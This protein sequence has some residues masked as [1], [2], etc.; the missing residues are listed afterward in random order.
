MCFPSSRIKSSLL[1]FMPIY[2]GWIFIAV[3][4]KEKKRK[5]KI[6]L[7]SPSPSDPLTAGTPKADKKTRKVKGYQRRRVLQAS[8]LLPSPQQYRTLPPI[9]HRLEFVEEM[10]RA[11]Q[12][13]HL[14]SPEAKVTLLLALRLLLDFSRQQQFTRHV[15]HKVPTSVLTCTVSCAVL[16]VSYKKVCH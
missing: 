5:N 4:W 13:G 12:T 8:R 7:Q 16:S 14:T 2:K 1:A 6:H 9:L 10:H 3:S 15:P 11:R